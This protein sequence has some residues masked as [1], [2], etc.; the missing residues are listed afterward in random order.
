MTE[1]LL[2]EAIEKQLLPKPP[3]KIGVAVSGGGDSVALLALLARFVQDHDVE[4][5]VISIDHGLRIGTQ[6]EIKLVTQ[7][8]ARFGCQH[9]VEY[10][11]GWDGGGNLQD[12][13]RT[14]RYEL[15][16]DW[17][18]ANDISV[19]M[20]GHTANDQAETLMMRLARGAGVDGLSAMAARR[21]QGGVTWVRPLLNIERR[22]L[23]HYL[24][25]Q[26][27]TWTEDPSN[28]NRDFERIRMRDAL[29]LLEPLG[30][31]VENLIAVA[32]QMSKARVALNWQAFLAAKDVAQVSHGAICINMKGFRALPEEISRR[33]LVHALVWLSNSD[34]PPRRGAV[35]KAREAIRTDSTFTLHGCQIERD[36]ET[37]WVFREFNA[38]RDLTAEV[39]DVWDDR[40]YVDGAEDDPELQVRALGPD[41]LAQVPC[42]RE[43]GLPRAALMTT[44]GVFMGAD[45]IASPVIGDDEDWTAELDGGADGFFAA[46]LSH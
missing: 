31:A 2:L 18:V 45:L 5:H 7:I 1:P 40:W 26:N 9:H 35:E 25:E 10:W 13:A 14:A 29:R 4:L 12:R 42:W 44:P 23:R 22:T 39:G 21:L 20:L 27:L 24:Q 15:I 34:Y 36:G 46:L 3:K 6:Q 41:G 33:L 11:S 30:F 43:A 17:A 28:E 8:C 19:V 32:D 37:L 16:G 38:V